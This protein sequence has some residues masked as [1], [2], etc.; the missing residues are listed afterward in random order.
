MQILLISIK[1]SD[2]ALEKTDMLVP[3]IINITNWT[4]TIGNIM[5]AIYTTIILATIEV[6]E[7]L[8]N[9][10][11]WYG[12]SPILTAIITAK[13]SGIFFGICGIIK[14]IESAAKNDIWK[15]GL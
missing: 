13:K 9:W 2:N 7:K 12:R 14:I 11:T 8:L 5:L 6:T 1:N 3:V 15:D 4:K 10:Y